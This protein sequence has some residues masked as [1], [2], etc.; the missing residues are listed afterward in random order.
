MDLVCCLFLNLKGNYRVLPHT[1]CDLTTYKRVIFVSVVQVR[2]P[3]D[4]RSTS[5]SVE[6]GV[7]RFDYLS[8]RTNSPPTTYRYDQSLFTL[9]Y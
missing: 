3:L 4:V 6:S 5:N 9:R 7:V 2:G 8:K 1:D